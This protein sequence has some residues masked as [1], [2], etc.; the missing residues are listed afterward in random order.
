MNRSCLPSDADDEK[1]VRAFYRIFGLDDSDDN[2]SSTKKNKTK[3]RMKRMKRIM[4]TNTTTWNDPMQPR[5]HDDVHHRRRRPCRCHLTPLL[6]VL[7]AY[8]ADVPHVLLEIV[9]CCG[10]RGTEILHRAG[11]TSVLASSAERYYHQYPPQPPSPPFLVG[12]LSLLNAM[13]IHNNN[14]TDGDNVVAR[15]EEIAS[16]AARF[17]RSH[18]PS[19]ERSVRTFPQQIDITSRF[20]GRRSK[21]QDWFEVLRV[22]YFLGK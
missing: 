4:T 11:I 20:L 14:N 7:E 15:R 22:V 6:D 9:R 8:D 13:L 1:I 21:N 5:L 10:G 2:D 12:H 18:E 19:F 3:M 16:C 17:L